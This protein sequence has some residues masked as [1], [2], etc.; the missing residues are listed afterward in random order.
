[1]LA[2]RKLTI[3]KFKFLVILFLFSR[4]FTF[5]ALAQDATSSG[6]AIKATVD[7][8][9]VISGSIICSSNSGYK[10]CDTT[11]DS[12]L[13]GVVTST[14][15]V[16]IGDISANREYY[17]LNNGLALVNVTTQNGPIKENDLITT[18]NISGVGQKATVNGYVLGT[19]LSAY[20]NPDTSQVGKIFVSINIHP[21]TAFADVRSNLFQLLRRGISSAV[22]TP[23]AALRYIL[24]SI[25]T[26]VS[27]VLGFVYFGRLAKT[28]VEAVGR[29][30]LAQRKIEAI[31]LLH[32]IITVAIFVSGLAL[33]FMIIAV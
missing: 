18:S 30:P 19:A 20:D 12:N 31:V 15:S 4:I 10:M 32:I 7:Q 13:F 2:I 25:V 23:I 1:M 27:F 22:L 26:I 33:A 24:A 16:S 17:I 14:P 9:K 3:L 8:D 28:G 5:N 11:Y 29:N 21:S 6:V